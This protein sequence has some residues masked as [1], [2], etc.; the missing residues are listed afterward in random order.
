MTFSKDSVDLVRVSW[1]LQ[2]QICSVCLS[3]QGLEAF[4]QGLFAEAEEL[5]RNTFPRKVVELDT[6]LKVR[7]S[8]CRC[9]PFSRKGVVRLSVCFSNIYFQGTICLD[10][11]SPSVLICRVSLN[12]NT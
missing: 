6:L 2:I 8:A 5:V 1:D 9:L 10:L 3:V 7:S 4:K 12:Y 11:P